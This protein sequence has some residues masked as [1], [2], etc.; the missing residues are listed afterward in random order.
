MY[1][2]LR[3]FALNQVFNSFFLEMHLEIVLL[4]FISLKILVNAQSFHNYSPVIIS[5]WGTEDFQ[6]AAQKSLI[7]N[8]GR[9]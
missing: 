1:K 6:I 3:S 5:T 8:K 9:I 4:L 7:S 2:A